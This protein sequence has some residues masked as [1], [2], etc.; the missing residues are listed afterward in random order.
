M[1]SIAV[2]WPNRLG[3]PELLS[4]E[5]V[6][7]YENVGVLKVPEITRS[8]ARD[9]V[10]ALVC[11]GGIASEVKRLVRLPMYI[12]TS[13]YLDVLETFRR[14]EEEQNIYHQRVA[15]LLHRANTLN[16]E[17]LQPFVN[18]HI[19]LFTFLDSEDI[20]RALR[21]IASL[22]FDA[23][24]TGPTGLSFSKSAGVPAYPIIYSEETALDGIRQAREILA[25][26]S[27]QLRQMIRMQATIDASPDAI[28]STDSRGNID[29][30]NRRAR[31]ILRLDSTDLIGKNI[32]RILKDPSWKD[33]YEKGI[34]QQNS[35]IELGGEHYFSSRYPVAQGDSI[36]GTV[37]TLQ[38]TGQIQSM[39]SKYRAMQAGGFTA[40]Y[41]F[42]HILRKGGRMEELI[43]QAEVVAKTGLSVLIEGE[44]GTGKEMFAQ[45][46][47]NASRRRRGPFVAV[48]CAALPESLLESELMGYEEGAFTGA[49]KGGKAGLFE[50]AHGGTLFLD[51]IN[52]MSLPLQAKLLRV[53]QE[54]M[55]RRVGGSRMIPVDV[56]I[57]TAANESLETKVREGSFRNDLYYRINMIRFVLPP[58]RERSGDIPVL[59]KH[60]ARESGFSLPE[61]DISLIASL[62]EGY[63]WPGNIRELENYVLRSAALL[64]AG[65]RSIDAPG[66]NRPAF[67]G[68]SPAAAPKPEQI[69]LRPGSLKEMEKDLIRQ[70]LSRNGGNLSRTARELEVTRNTVHAKLKE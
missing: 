47:H 26:S 32:C 25:T 15:L 48:N 68:D 12:V 7:V 9:G 64:S 57:L 31:E 62:A 53:I 59:L 51:E 54:Q 39:E 44:T 6:K 41:Q 28:I 20:R 50:M 17:R 10:E 60:F 21:R 16:L 38:D 2:L 22:G 34:P 4:A 1:N 30:V 29:M 63:F 37:G 24:V 5:D 35:L 18:N 46:I 45:G 14:L 33:V 3:R 23:V 19:E 65:M 27:K 13:G 56:R 61:E 42:K 69:T 52:Q 70:M 49:R 8:F 11:T 66:E 36:I 43:R 40:R 58:L 67:P 55:V